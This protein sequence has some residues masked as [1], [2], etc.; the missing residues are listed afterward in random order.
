MKPVLIIGCGTPLRAD[1]GVA[2]HVLES[3]QNSADNTGL[4]LEPVHQLT[5]ELAEAI[6]KAD[7]VIFVDAAEGPAGQVVVKLVDSTA[8]AAARLTHSLTPA[9]LLSLSRELYGRAPAKAFLVLVG[10][11]SFELS[12]KLSEPVARSVAHAMNAIRQIICEKQ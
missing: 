2:W 7:T 9:S 10:G 5:P 3:L 4:V 1:D 6:S 8:S 11:Y 12:E